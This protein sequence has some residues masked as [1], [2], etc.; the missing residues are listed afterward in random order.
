MVLECPGQPCPTTA[1]TRFPCE[2]RLIL[3]GVQQ[4]PKWF[5]T[6][7]VIE[8]QL[9]AFR[10]FVDTHLYAFD[11]RTICMSSLQKPAVPRNDVVPRVAGD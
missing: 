8:Q 11:R 6:L 1:V 10:P 4:V 7:L 2:A 3:T 9:D 5:A